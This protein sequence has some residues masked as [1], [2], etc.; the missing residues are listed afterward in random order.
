MFDKFKIK[1]KK[2]L[3]FTTIVFL[4]LVLFAESLVY[5][6]YFR[7]SVKMLGE[8][9]SSRVL[10]YAL[11][12]QDL[13]N[14]PFKL[15]WELAGGTKLIYQIGLEDSEQEVSAEALIGAKLILEQ[16]F[17]IYQ[18]NAQVS[19][20]KKNIVVEIGAGEDVETIIEIV[21]QKFSV[22]FREEGEGG[23]YFQPTDLT[24]DYLDSVIFAIDQ[25]DQKPLI[26]L[27]F[28]EEGAKILEALTKKNEGKRLGIYVDE[29]P[30][31]PLQIKE[32]ISGGDVQIKMDASLDLVKNLTRI[33]SISSMSPSFK[34]ISQKSRTAEEAQVLLNNTIKASLFAL[35][36]IFW[37]A[38]ILY[39]LSGFVSFVLVLIYSLL[40][41]LVCKT[42]SFVIDS[43]LIA[44]LWFSIL[45]AL[46]SLVLTLKRIKQELRKGKSFSIAFEEGFETAK[47]MVK[48]VHFI[49]LFL[50][51][52]I[53]GVAVA[54]FT[55][56]GFVKDFVS[57]GLLGILMSW[58]FIGPL[59]KRLLFPFEDTR[60]S[61]INYLWQ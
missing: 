14:K 24:G 2:K 40:L 6:N 52:L 45:I 49:G 12:S 21:N 5:P 20:D 48:K 43:S 54:F 18:K 30:V 22:D 33:M 25:S 36:A 51:I 39:K 9:I 13:L 59:L 50:L 26:V 35:L 29:I 27:G 16:R 38:V 23:G 61:K 32:A 34:M 55:E 11:E 58:L 57:I 47:P 46:I 1:N 41:L 42:T 44:G 17:E 31:L 19:I 53:W 37:S 8:K 3:Y 15:G 10:P 4:L 56:T 28:N 60:L 7:K